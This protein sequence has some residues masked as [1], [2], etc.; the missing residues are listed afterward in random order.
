VTPDNVFERLGLG[1]FYHIG[2]AVR[3]MDEAIARLKSLGMTT[4]PVFELTVPSTYRGAPTEARVK[5]AFAPLG[6]I[7]LE[8]VEPTGGESSIAAFLEARGEGV[9]HF[10]YRVDDLG[11]T[12]ES[13]KQLGIAMEWLVED[14]HGPAVAFLAGDAFFGVNVELVRKQP[15]INLRASTPS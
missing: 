4:G 6:A 7:A 10:G 3:N 5:A 1:D 15:P 8:L 12:L 11:T 9:Q 14:E 13:A 2:M